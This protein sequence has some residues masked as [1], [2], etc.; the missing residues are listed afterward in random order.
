VLAGWSGSMVVMASMVFGFT[1][2]LGWSYYGQICLEYFFGLKVILPYRMVFLT[3]LFAG[4]LFTGRWAPIVTN[5]GDICNASLAIPNLIGL[6]LLSG[7]VRR[8]TR[9]A[10]AAGH[11]NV[12]EAT[13][14]RPDH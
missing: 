7:V 6:V 12:H 14:L 5:L 3:S 4:A 1:T 2:L 10:Y 13:P 11:F 9:D 8:L